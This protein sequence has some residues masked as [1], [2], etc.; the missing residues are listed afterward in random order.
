M[1][2]RAEALAISLEAPE[3]A[4]PASCKESCQP[5]PVWK[6]ISWPDPAVNC[7]SKA[8]RWQEW[9]CMPRVTCIFAFRTLCIGYLLFGG[10]CVQPLLIKG[11]EGILMRSAPV[12]TRNGLPR[13]SGKILLHMPVKNWSLASRFSLSTLLRV[14]HVCIGLRSG[15][16][17]CVS[18]VCSGLIP[19]FLGKSAILG[20]SACDGYARGPILSKPLLPLKVHV[21]LSLS[22]VSMVRFVC[23]SF[24]MGLVSPMRS[25]SRRSLRLLVWSWSSRMN[26]I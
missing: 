15:D 17:G 2:A 18:W 13:G 5:S 6:A 14:Y 23:K 19:C 16:H 22:W 3:L 10:S 21:W 9:K 1:E 12:R 4:G 20:L 7:M 11:S 26:C 24:P 25:K 8:A